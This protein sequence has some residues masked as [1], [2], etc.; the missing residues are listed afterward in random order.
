MAM[1]LAEFTRQLV[2]SELMSKDEVR[3]FR[4]E[5]P[6][7]KRTDEVQEFARELVRQKKITGYQASAVYQGKGS[8]LQLGGYTILDK[9]GQGGMGMV[10]KAEHR[11]MKRIVALKVLPPAATKSPDNVKRFHREVQAAARM[12]HPNIVAAFDAGEANKVH[13]L[14]MEFVDGSD[15]SQIVK[16]Q[17]PLPVDKAVQC[18][19]QAAR[20]LEAAHEAGIVH[21]DIKPANLL[22]DHSGVVKILDM[23]LARLDEGFSGNAGAAGAGMTQTG[24]IMGTVDYMSPE[25]ALNTK[26]ADARADI[27][28]L[29]C[30]LYYLLTGRPP[31]QGETLMEKLLAHRE[32]PIPSLK[33][34]CA[35]APPALEAVYV[36]MVAKQPHERYQSPSEVIRDLQASLTAEA[37]AF[38]SSNSLQ[39]LAAAP[40]EE[41][42]LLSFLRQ[43]AEP[44]IAVEGSNRFPS[45][46]ASSAT[47][48]RTPTSDTQ[49]TLSRSRIRK[50]PASAHRRQLFVPLAASGVVALLLGIWWL[51]R[52]RG[53]KV[54]SNATAPARDSK[55]VV[56]KSDETAPVDY[57]LSFRRGKAGSRVTVPS[58]KIRLDQPI[59]IEG[60]LT[61]TEEAGQQ[62]SL[63]ALDTINIRGERG[64]W[65]IVTWKEKGTINSE[66]SLNVELFQ[67]THVALVVDPGKMARLFVNGELA[68]SQSLGEFSV[69]KAERPL[70][71]GFDFS[72]VIDEV[73]ISNVARYRSNFTPAKR[74]SSD[75]N[76]LALFHF[77]E[78]TGNQLTD[79]SGRNNHGQ[80]VGA[81]WVVAVKTK[82]ASMATS[83]ASTDYA[84]HFLGE[85]SE[86][87]IPD[88]K[89]SAT[90][91]YTIEGYITATEATGREQE[92]MVFGIRDQSF[93][94]YTKANLFRWFWRG[95]SANVKEKWITKVSAP[96]P[97]THIACVRSDKSHRLFIDGKIFRDQGDTTPASGTAMFKIGENF[98]GMIDEV[99]VSSV[100]RYPTTFLPKRRFEPDPDT[101]ALYHFDEGAGTV[102]KDS[103]GKNRHGTIVGAQ[104][105]PADQSGVPVL[106]APPADYALE[107]PGQTDK[108]FVQIGDNLK[109]DTGRAFTLE[110]WVTYAELSNF[111]SL[112]T[113]PRDNSSTKGPFDPFITLRSGANRPAWN[114][115]LD[116]IVLSEDQLFVLKKRVHAALVFDMRQLRLYVDGVIADRRNA[117]NV[118]P[119][120]MSGAYFGH[121]LDGVLDEVRISQ[122]AR[123]S[124]D[125]NPE[126][127]FS[128]DTNTLALYHFDE[129][130]GDVLK[131][132]SGN[133]RHGKIIGAKWVP[134]ELPPTK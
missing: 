10:F 45:L 38:A 72:G 131:D 3:A 9:L 103:S 19:V 130:A 37:N 117:P 44:T 20:G 60:Y 95:G 112:V 114:A 34:L 134:A 1:S 64:R 50:R 133:N 119:Q 91:P 128:S 66:S 101:L 29:G 42:E 28:S 80:I 122:S 73:R 113:I 132:S 24:A 26:N 43:Q 116:N 23:G 49:R 84:L 75:N 68:V 86:V 107:F 76:T 57:A 12:T 48:A 106:S 16:K 90:A 61:H 22:L 52:D 62:T 89:F 123:Y 127:R 36:R 129:G 96:E 25:Q 11:T 6:P 108:A 21:R 105:V 17:G 115:A 111:G 51:A 13:F 102:L 67:R 124:K 100:A 121:R 81:E 104:W 109:L 46:E 65:K 125:F 87:A 31:Y 56:E 94:G 98:S 58:L 2:E 27:Y 33:P 30:S 79:D 47:V 40:E 7:E 126:L 83:P 41:S 39:Q 5:L 71:M 99:R 82:S 32:Q 118:P 8:S 70:E 14:V 54:D 59:T 69:T 74:F 35:N 88:L 120:V 85:G 97:R 78:G 18:I 110:G 55:A 63:F 4:A 92:S 53:E 77:D 93:L 15:L